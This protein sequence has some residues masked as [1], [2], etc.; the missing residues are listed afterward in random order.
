MGTRWE[1]AMSRA[2][3]FQ[4]YEAFFLNLYG[5]IPWDKLPNSL[6]AAIGR[7]VQV[8]ISFSTVIGDK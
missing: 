2:K 1:V 3:A 8:A 7:F 4:K 6:G 5:T